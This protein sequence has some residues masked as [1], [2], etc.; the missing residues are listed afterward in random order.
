MDVFQVQERV[1]WD[2]R[3]FTSG[4]VQPRAPRTPAAVEGQ[5]ARGLQWPDPW[6]SL[7]PSFATG[8]A[9]SG[10]PFV[11]PL[12]PPPGSRPRHPERPR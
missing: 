3:A 6:L 11:S 12:E 2:Y 1:V 7:N 10:T 9:A 5:F 8:G 4:F